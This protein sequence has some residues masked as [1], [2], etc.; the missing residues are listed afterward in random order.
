MAK[1]KK[2]NTVDVSAAVELVTDSNVG[3]KLEVL[4][5]GYTALVSEVVKD[6]QVEGT[7]LYIPGV[8][9][10]TLRGK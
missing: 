10:K 9:Y 8:T 4:D 5:V 3:T 1:L 7:I 2:I 6:G